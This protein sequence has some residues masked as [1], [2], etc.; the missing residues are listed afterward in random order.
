MDKDTK[1]D[2]IISTDSNLAALTKAI[3][4]S[5][6]N[7]E[8]L[9]EALV[10]EKRNKWWLEHLE[11]ASLTARTEW[12]NV[13]NT[14]ELFFYVMSVIDI[15]GSNINWRKDSDEYYN[16]PKYDKEANGKNITYVNPFIKDKEM[17]DIN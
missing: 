13:Y 14:L 10:R 1:V 6:K 15:N 8:C 4:D 7:V 16:F 11:V 3:T 9:E 12:D 5:K 17:V 2:L